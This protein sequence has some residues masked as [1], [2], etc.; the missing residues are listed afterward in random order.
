MM[1]LELCGSD[2]QGADGRVSSLSL[3]LSLPFRLETHQGVP[4]CMLGRRRALG[5]SWTNAPEQRLRHGEW[6]VVNS[7]IFIKRKKKYVTHWRID[8]N[9]VCFGDLFV[10]LLW[11]WG[12]RG[13]DG[14]SNASPQARGTLEEMCF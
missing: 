1:S 14:A 13:E 2:L 9:L 10:V 6:S 5:L 7:Q 3:R 8:M 11:L 12:D 4:L